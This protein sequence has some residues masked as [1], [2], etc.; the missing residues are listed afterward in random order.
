MLGDC[1]VSSLT[2]KGL[3]F[4]QK[5]CELQFAHEEAAE[6]K[7]NTTKFTTPHEINNEIDQIHLE[8]LYTA[9]NIVLSLVDL[10]PK[11]VPKDALNIFPHDFHTWIEN[12]DTIELSVWINRL[13]PLIYKSMKKA[14][15]DDTHPFWSTH[16]QTI[17]FAEK[18]RIDI[19]KEF[20]SRKTIHI[21][22]KN[23]PF[24]DK[25]TSYFPSPLPHSFTLHIIPD[26]FHC[27][28]P[29]PPPWFFSMC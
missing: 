28:P 15:L 24:V 3:K 13:K 12:T 27:C 29:D 6:Y 10:K 8:H 26:C 23:T 21:H 14:Q 18:L 17:C 11:I 2:T 9:K 20:L 22:T 5:L 19:Y 25:L 4:W 7:I 16:K 1:L